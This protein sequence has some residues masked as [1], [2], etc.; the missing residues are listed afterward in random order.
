MN[1]A[2]NKNITQLQYVGKFG[3]PTHSV[4]SKMPRWDIAQ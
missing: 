1:W 4:L 3:H 2:K